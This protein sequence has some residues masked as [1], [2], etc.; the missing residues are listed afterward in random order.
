MVSN[1]MKREVLNAWLDYEEAV[2]TAFHLP[3]TK[4]MSAE[5]LEGLFRVGTDDTVRPSISF[6]RRQAEE[7]RSMKFVGEK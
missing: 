1:E 6:L 7:F 5:G 4:H 2:R 3:A